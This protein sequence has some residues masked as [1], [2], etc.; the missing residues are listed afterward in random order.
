MHKTN[1]WSRSLVNICC[2][3]PTLA[4]SVDYQPL[5]VWT[6]TQLDLFSPKHNEAVG[7]SYFVHL[8]SNWKQTKT[9][10]CHRDLHFSLIMN[11]RS[12]IK[13][14]L[15]HRLLFIHLFF[16]SFCFSGAHTAVKEHK[17]K[18]QTANMSSNFDAPTGR[19]PQPARKGK[20]RALLCYL[21]TPASS[22]QTLRVLIVRRCNVHYSC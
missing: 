16:F 10:N 19:M 6:H 15:H 14:K 4:T 3:K 9:C 2:F 1:V 5:R 17:W 22:G 7:F 20:S 11:I 18:W 12:L 13:L 8:D 21:S